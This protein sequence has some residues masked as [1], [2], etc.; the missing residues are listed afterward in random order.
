VVLIGGGIAVGLGLVAVAALAAV[1]VTAPGHNALRRFLIDQMGKAIDGT[2]EVGSVS[3][4]LWRAA[5]L[6]HVTLRSRDGKPVIQVE[7]ARVTYALTDLVRGRFRFSGVTL[8]RPVVILEQQVDRHWNIEHLFKTKDQPNKAHGPRPLVDLRDVVLSDGTVIIRERPPGQRGFHQRTVTGVNATF[9]RLRPSHPDSTAIEG[10]FRRLSAR[11]DEPAIDIRDARG[12]AS[13]DGDSVHFVLDRIALPNSEAVMSG[14][15]RW[16]RGRTAVTADIDASRFTFADARGV[17]PALPKDGGG[18]ASLLVTLPGDNTG[19]VDIRDADVRIGRSYVAGK[20]TVIVGS[21]G[22]VT[23]RGVDLLLRPLDLALL[24]PYV[25]S[26]PVRGLVRGTLRGSGS[27]SNVTFAANL[28][29][30]DESVEGVP[31][32]TVDARGRLTLGGREQLTFHGVTVHRADFDLGTI[33]RFAPSIELEGRLRLAGTLDGPWKDAQFHGSL[34][35]DGEGDEQSVVR[36]DLRL[37]LRETTHIDAELAVGT[38]SFALLRRTYPQI[39]LREPMS[40]TASVHG[41]MTGLNI[42]LSLRGTTGTLTATGTVGVRGSV[43]SVQ[44]QGLFDSLDIAHISPGTAPPS[45]LWGRWTAD[46]RVPEDSTQPSTGA[47]RLEIQRGRLAG[48]AVGAGGAALRLEP[49]RME[50]EYARLGF[51]GG[52]VNASGA[53]GRGAG[54]ASRLTFEL[55]AD[56]V[57]YLEPLLRWARRESG[58][59]STV[60]L[61]GSAVV[62]GSVAGTTRSWQLDADG[63]VSAM[64]LGSALGRNLRARGRLAHDSSGYTMSL[65]G[66]ADTLAAAGLVYS[67]VGLSLAGRPDSLTVRANA[68]FLSRSALRAAFTFWKDTDRHLKADSLEIDL[69]VHKWRLLRPATMLVASDVIRLDTL[70]LRSEEG[71]GYLRASGVLPRTGLADFALVADSVSLS[72]VYAVLQRDTAGIS[73]A[74]NAQASVTGPAAAPV[75]DVRAA[76][77]DGRFGDYRLPLFQVLAHYEQRRLTIKGGL[78]RDTLRLVSINGSLPVDL[79]LESVPHRK[80]PGDLEVVARSDS[81]DMQV[82]DPLIEVVS[83]LSGRMALDVRASGTWDSPEYQGYVDVSGGRMTVPSLGTS[84]QGIDARLSLQHNV[85]TV[86]RL[87]MGGGNGVLDAGGTVTFD[88]AFSARPR[89]DLSLNFNRFHAINIAEFGGFTGTG[90]FRLTGPLLGATL[91]G[92]A[93]IDEGYLQFADLVQKRVVSLDDPEFRAMVDSSLT[94]A[95]LAPGAHVIFFDSLRVEGVRLTMGPDVWLRSSEAN[96]QL[97]GEFVVDRTIEDQLARYRIDGTLRAVRGSY[98]LVL[99]LENSVFSV[100]R[101]FRVTRGTVRF[102]GTPDFNPELDIAAEHQARTVQGQPLLVRVLIGGTLLYPTLQLESDARPPLTQTELVSYLMFGVPPSGAQGTSGDVGLNVVTG[103]LVSGVGQALASELGLP[104][105]YLTI[106]TG[107]GHVAGTPAGTS[108]ARIEAGTQLSDKA[109]LTLNA[110]LCEVQTSSLLGASLEYRL[111]NRWTAS[112]AFEPV[113]QQCGTAR[114]LAGLNSK[115][116]L[117]FDLFWQSGIR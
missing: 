95:D 24:A 105:S 18:R 40:G 29:W 101:D 31:T 7:R 89:L 58:D 66:S 22:G 90:Q 23:V 110:G 59:S 47:V 61:D 70:E 10:R 107:S 63:S 36:G 84:Y 81:L 60:K 79:S 93:V 52:S 80:L 55:R 39:P 9:G 57:G 68:G 53:V 104:L 46:L 19:L 73:G 32:N 94:Q 1:L 88:S 69:P 37:G 54:A 108:S 12:F 92:N 86:S 96:I 75:I 3:G 106:Q 100:T 48:V 28:A 78:W 98:K 56:T 72:D 21:H 6:E 11:L 15:I 76:L 43:V 85:M 45:A 103:N 102:F 114:A 49:G 44:A 50:V 2:V 8:V 112:A 14:L 27:L 64:D 116:Q 5:D 33:H 82:L 17:V 16:D 41:P 20:G 26:L 77:S 38:L 91:T 51:S 83:G 97:D 42:A 109:F 71:V 35:H 117:G 34:Y 65:N 62:T 115:F 113:V 99:G 13:L 30:D 67:P 25:D 74:A 87:Q 111:T 4:A